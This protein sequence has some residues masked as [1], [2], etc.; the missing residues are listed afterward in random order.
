MAGTESMNNNV[1]FGKNEYTERAEEAMQTTLA[2]LRYE[3]CF[4]GWLCGFDVDTLDVLYFFPIEDTGKSGFTE[5][6]RANHIS[7][8]KKNWRKIYFEIVEE[9]ELAEFE[10]F[11]VGFKSLFF[12][13]RSLYR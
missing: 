11:P 13:L 5:S 8:A 7:K 4:S 10:E 1:C 3:F 9:K 2:E 12:R 6:D